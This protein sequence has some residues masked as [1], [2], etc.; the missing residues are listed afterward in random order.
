MTTGFRCREFICFSID[1]RFR[2]HIEV[3]SD[4][5]FRQAAPQATHDIHNRLVCFRIYREI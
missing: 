4:P 2:V 5:T 1:L 3:R